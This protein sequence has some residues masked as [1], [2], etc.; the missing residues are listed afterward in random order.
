[1]YNAVTMGR[2]VDDPLFGAESPML[3]L[4]HPASSGSRYAVVY[5]CLDTPLPALLQPSEGIMSVCSVLEHQEEGKHL[6]ASDY[7]LGTGQ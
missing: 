6:R 2:L 1:M 3:T 5:D 7:P 4:T